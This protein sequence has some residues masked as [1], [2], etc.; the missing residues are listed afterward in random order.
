MCCSVKLTA[1]SQNRRTR[2]FKLY[3]NKNKKYLIVFTNLV[4]D[5]NLTKVKFQ[6]LTKKNAAPKELHLY[7]KAEIIKS[8]VRQP[9]NRNG[10]EA[11]REQD[12]MRVLDQSQLRELRKAL[13][14]AKLDSY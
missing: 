7:L 10:D 13:W 4:R 9:P 5:Q 12:L 8:T 11:R 2:Q 3:F 6:L 1:N 14:L